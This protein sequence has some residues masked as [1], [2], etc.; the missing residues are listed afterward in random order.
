MIM[1]RK[2]DGLYVLGHT[3]IWVTIRVRLLTHH[4]KYPNQLGRCRD[5]SSRKA[6]ALFQAIAS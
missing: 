6:A 1:I 4:S 2:Q 5:K 3:K